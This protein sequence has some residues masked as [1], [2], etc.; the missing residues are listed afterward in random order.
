MDTTDT[1]YCTTEV[2]EVKILQ[3]WKNKSTDERI[4]KITNKR[5][6]ISEELHPTLPRSC[7]KLLTYMVDS[8]T[9]K[10]ILQPNVETGTL[11]KD[12]RSIDFDKDSPLYKYR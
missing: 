9:G 1:Y 5:E 6:Q 3:T 4:K 12:F 7:Y 11:L 2:G 10:F 8:V